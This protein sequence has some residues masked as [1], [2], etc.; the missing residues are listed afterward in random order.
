M[1]RASSLE[2]TLM[3]GKTEDRR[4]GAQRMRWFNGIINSRDMS[5]S[6]FQE[7]QRQGSLVCCSPWGPKESEKT[8]GLNNDKVIGDKYLRC[9]FYLYSLHYY[10]NWELSMC[11]LNI[12]SSMNCLFA[13]FSY[14]HFLYQW[15]PAYLV[16]CI[17][18]DLIY[19]TLMVIFHCK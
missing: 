11:L 6:Q 3:L 2:K 18:C 1:W 12:I 9:I 15:N 14:I 8:E 19:A 5:L 13:S 17:K 10:W 4:K 7:S 16:F